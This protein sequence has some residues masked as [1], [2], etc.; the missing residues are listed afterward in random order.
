MSYDFNVGASFRASSNSVLVAHTPMPQYFSTPAA[1]SGS[2][3]QPSHLRPPADDP[4]S[5]GVEAK[6][7]S[8][9]AGL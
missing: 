2:T 9:N 6:S 1:L 4:K 5:L 7:D 8:S 3:N